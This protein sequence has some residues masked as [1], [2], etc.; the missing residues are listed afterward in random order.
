MRAVKTR[1]S[2]ARLV[3]DKSHGAG[4]NPHNP[5]QFAGFSAGV[6]YPDAYQQQTLGKSKPASVAL[7]QL[8]QQQ[9]Q[10]QQQQQQQQY[11]A[12]QEQLQQLQQQ[13]QAPLNLPS[14]ADQMQAAFLDYQRQRMEFEQQ[15]QQL[16]QKLYTYYPDVSGQQQH[17]LHHELPHGQQQHQPNTINS[18]GGRFFARQ[19]FGG[20]SNGLQPQPQQRQQTQQ[21]AQL[22]QL[23]QLTQLS[24]L[25]QLAQLPQQAQ[26]A[27]PAGGLANFYSTQ[28][29]MGFMQ[30][31][32]QNVLRDQQQNV[33][34][35]FATG[36]HAPSTSTNYG[37]AVPDS[38][39]LAAAAYQPAS[40]VS[41]VRFS[42]GNLNYNF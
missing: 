12:Q 1:R 26:P 21:Q 18:D 6:Q 36:Q 2:P 27:A 4:K 28:Q 24:Q 31:Q 38:P 7:S 42:S 3:K 22:P 23:P 40:A 33:A 10:Q 16:L 14:Y 35:Q 30:Q 20:A 13:Q 34:Q 15:Q 11:L 17:Q 37:M 9:E 25:P 19:A 8:Q 32:Q 41:H 5:S 39:E 29:H